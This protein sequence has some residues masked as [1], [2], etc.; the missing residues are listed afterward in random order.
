MPVLL[1][2]SEG[3]RVVTPKN[4]AAFAD[5][6]AARGVKVTVV[7]VPGGHGGALGHDAALS[8]IKR[9]LDADR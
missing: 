9:F 8:A 1:I 7:S 6:L 4:M 2:V 5:Q 3:D